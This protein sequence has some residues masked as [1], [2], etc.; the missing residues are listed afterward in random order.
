MLYLSMLLNAMVYMPTIAL[1][2]TVLP[3]QMLPVLK[4]VVS[5][6][7]FCRRLQRLG[8]PQRR[9]DSVS[10]RDSDSRPDTRGRH[11]PMPLHFFSAIGSDS[12]A[13]Y[14]LLSR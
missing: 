2:N 1:N 8:F 5:S 12:T 14:P 10:Y 13:S 9:T 11:R 7:V 4:S 3:P 6:T